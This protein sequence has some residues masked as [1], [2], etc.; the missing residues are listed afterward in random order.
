MIRRAV[1]E[2]VLLELRDGASNGT[3]LSGVL[4]M[5]G[6]RSFEVQGEVS[7]DPMLPTLPQAA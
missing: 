6:Y 7:Y 5:T 4:M 2:G 1:Y 3:Y